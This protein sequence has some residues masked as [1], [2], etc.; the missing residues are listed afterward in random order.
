MILFL[1]LF[2]SSFSYAAGI[3]AIHQVGTCLAEEDI[4]RD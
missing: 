3:E 4:I 1:K 2:K